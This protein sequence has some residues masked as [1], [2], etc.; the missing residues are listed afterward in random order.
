MMKILL[1]VFLILPLTF[2]GQETKKVKGEYTYI[3]EDINE[4]VGSA[5]RKALE[6][7]QTDALKQAFGESIYHNNYTLVENHSGQSSIQFVSSGGSEV[8]GEWLET[9]DEPIYDINYKDG[10]LIVKVVVKGIVRQVIAAGVNFSVKILRNGIEDKFESENFKS[11]DN[12]YISFQSSSD[13]FVAIYLIDDDGIANCLLPYQNQTQGIYSIK[14]NKKYVFFSPKSVDERERYFVDK[15][16]FT[17]SKQQ[18]VNQF[19]IIFSPNLFSKAVDNSIS[20]ELPRRLK[21]TDF[22]NWLA[23]CRKKDLSMKV[24]KKTVRITK[25]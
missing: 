22:E 19:Y 24:E 11:N 21:V 20:P 2:F 25:Q 10:F 4:S 9:I 7:A 18:E 6:R 15:Y 8:R 16:Y 23:N 12:F 3:S 14:S 5:K 13:G 1:L 17:C